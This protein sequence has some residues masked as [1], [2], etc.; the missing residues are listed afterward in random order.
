MVIDPTGAVVPGAHVS[1]GA[2]SVR[3]DADGSFA[4]DVSKPGPGEGIVAVH[5]GFLPAF[6]RVSARMPVIPP[7]WVPIAFKFG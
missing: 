6:F 1:S 3:T 7:C 4:L 5:P 2:L